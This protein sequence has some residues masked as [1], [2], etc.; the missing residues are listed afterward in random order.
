MDSLGQLRY[1]KFSWQE[2]LHATDGEVRSEV[3]AFPQRAKDFMT[4]PSSTEFK[5]LQPTPPKHASALCH[6]PATHQSNGDI[7]G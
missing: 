3:M 1:R 5:R 7:P 4:A 2:F 6:G